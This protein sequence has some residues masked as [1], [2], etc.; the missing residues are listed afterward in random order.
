MLLDVCQQNDD[1]R[2]AVFDTRYSSDIFEH[3]L[4]CEY[5][6]GRNQ[7]Y[8]ASYAMQRWSF[9]KRK[10]ADLG[11]LIDLHHPFAEEIGYW[12]ATKSA[13]KLRRA[14]DLV[15]PIKSVSTM[16]PPFDRA[17]FLALRS[18]YTRP[19]R[20]SIPRAPPRTP[21]RQR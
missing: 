2:L 14:L 16:R 20:L 4:R 8:Y 1:G 5:F 7:R 17:R 10:T 21:K 13:I 12:L 15:M 18:E 6:T 19:N 11:P 9:Q 3:L